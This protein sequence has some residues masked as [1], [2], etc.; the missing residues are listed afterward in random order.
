MLKVPAINSIDK[1]I[2]TNSFDNI[3]GINSNSI[4]S[5]DSINS[6]D[7]I[8]S[9]DSIDNIDSIFTLPSGLS[10]SGSPACFGEDSQEPSFPRSTGLPCHLHNIV[11]DIL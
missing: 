3:D 9:I 5:N 7:N 10:P 8:I 2:S 11:H 4:N 6:I 1:I